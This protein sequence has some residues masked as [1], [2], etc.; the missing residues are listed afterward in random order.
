[1]LVACDEDNL[2]RIFSCSE[3]G[4]AK[5]EFDLNEFLNAGPDRTEADLEG[6]AR[7][8]N[9]A[10]WIGSHAA[11]EKGKP[12]PVRRRFFATDLMSKNGVMTIIPA[13][14]P[15]ATLIEDFAGHANL[16]ALPLEEAS[17]RAPEEDGGLNMEGLAEGPHDT[18][19]IALRSPLVEGKALIIPLEN[20]AAV[21]TGEKAVPGRPI[22]LDLGGLGIRDIHR[23]DA[24]HGYLIV[25]GPSAKKGPFRLYRWSGDANQAAE[26]LPQTTGDLRPEAVFTTPDQP[27]RYLLISDDSGRSGVSGWHGR[28]RLGRGSAGPQEKPAPGAPGDIA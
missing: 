22:P 16:A 12:R 27:S 5:A 4:P 17:R 3:D 24:A 15:C 2:L 19:L 13:G 6:A 18:L 14:K 23:M 28:G 21:V 25:A 26:L 10:Y 20:P 7:V 11:S 8:G 1:M 9:R